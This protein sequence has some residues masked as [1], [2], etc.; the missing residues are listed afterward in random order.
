MQNY[1]KLSIN[2]AL[3]LLLALSINSPSVLA[4]EKASSF[5]PQHPLSNLAY[6]DTSYPSLR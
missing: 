2:L 4:Q 5:L 6:L 3:S 1:E